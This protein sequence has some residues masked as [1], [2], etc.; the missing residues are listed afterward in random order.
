MSTTGNKHRK[1]TVKTNPPARSLQLLITTTTHQILLLLLLLL[2]LLKHDGENICQHCWPCICFHEYSTHF[3]HCTAAW[4]LEQERPKNHL[5][6]VRFILIS[7]LTII[8]S[9]PIPFWQNRI[10]TLVLSTL[11]FEKKNVVWSLTHP[12]RKY[13]TILMCF[14]EGCNI[15]SITYNK[16]AVYG[17]DVVVH[18]RSQHEARG[19]NC[20][21]RQL[22]PLEFSD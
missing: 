22:P 3:K 8:D 4:Y 6:L 15:A 5:H 14:Y 18:R 10:E 21:R 13:H 9:T 19:G 1:K 20:K 11:K 12:N 2:L 17:C 16:E 7:M